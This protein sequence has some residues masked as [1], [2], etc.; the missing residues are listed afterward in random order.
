L[1]FLEKRQ[2]GKEARFFSVIEGGGRLKYLNKE[3]I[4][5][6]IFC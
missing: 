6:I 4:F 3:A 5:S 1:A 2:V